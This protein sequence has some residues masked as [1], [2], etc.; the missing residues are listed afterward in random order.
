M[1]SAA[2]ILKKICPFDGTRIL[3]ENHEGRL[4]GT[5]TTL[6][7]MHAPIAGFPCSDLFSSSYEFLNKD[8][9]AQKEEEMSL[10]TETS[11]KNATTRM[12]KRKLQDD[13]SDSED[14]QRLKTAKITRRKKQ[15]RFHVFPNIQT[16]PRGV[17]S[18]WFTRRELCRMK[19]KAKRSCVT[20]NLDHELHTAYE[21][22]CSAAA[23][24][25]VENGSCCVSYKLLSESSVFRRQ[26]GLERWS[27]LAHYRARMVQ[28]MTCKTNF[29]I[30]QS[31][32][33]LQGRR[34]EHKLANI[35]MNTSRAA[36][37]FALFLG[38]ADAVAAAPSDDAASC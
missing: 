38:Q 17:G 21:S 5:T 30:E 15:V 34:D 33:L 6:F 20:I 31:M 14:E 32:Q 9:N 16:I 12:I 11:C 29:F 10:L 4:Q 27:S 18:T 26:R 24:S 7:H 13:L 3:V 25:N 22:C 19:R 37:Q 1:L 23:A 36:A 35:Y 28:R 2:D 8:F